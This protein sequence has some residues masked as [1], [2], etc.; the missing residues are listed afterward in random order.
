MIA[1]AADGDARRALNFLELAADLATDG[2]IDEAIAK[3]VVSGGRRRFD[4]QGEYF[5]DQISALHKSIRAAPIRMR[6]CT[7]CRA[8]SMVAVIRC[9]LPV[10]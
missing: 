6:P 10:A 1:T 2:R 7:G 9:T 4:K 5:Y 3:E 8:C